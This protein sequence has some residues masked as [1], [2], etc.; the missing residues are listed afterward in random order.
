MIWGR[1][2]GSVV[3]LFVG[4]FGVGFGFII[5]YL[6]DHVCNNAA[7][8]RII[9]GMLT[10]RG[11]PDTGE[12]AESA[13][14]TD[15]GSRPETRAGTQPGTQ[16]DRV[17]LTRVWYPDRELPLDFVAVVGVA[18][19]L[20]AAD[21]LVTDEQIGAVRLYTRKQFPVSV[22]GP[23]AVFFRSVV[24][25]AVILGNAIDRDGLCRYLGSALSLHEQ[26]DFLR[27]LYTVVSADPRGITDRDSGGVRGAG[28]IL[29]IP[30][31]R[32]K[33][34]TAT[35]IRPDP[36]DC[37]I[38]GISPDA[39]ETEIRS[40]YRRLAG[41]FHP[42][43]ASGLSDEQRQ[44]FHEAFVRIHDAYNRVMQRFENPDQTGP[45]SR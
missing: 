9:V 40:L 38:L 20:A 32:I 24:D 13:S 8:K 14:D 12:T 33:A 17:S 42:D 31:E 5:G 21:G 37:E 41:Q 11:L 6:V 1:V 15:S 28:R 19:S 30:D 22:S 16:P 34:I 26:E 10:G 45:V 7:Q 29:G 18:V 27:F 35:A 44:S 25:E 23:E 36:S 39:T 43:H 2:I 3:G 4:P